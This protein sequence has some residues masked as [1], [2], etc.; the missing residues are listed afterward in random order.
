VNAC[1]DRKDGWI[2]PRSEQSVTESFNGSET[3]FSTVIIRFFRISL[4]LWLRIGF[5]LGFGLYGTILFKPGIPSALQCVDC[6]VSPVEKLLRRPGASSFGRSATIDDDLLV[7]R[8]LIHARVDLVNRDSHRS[9]YLLVA[10]LP[11]AFAS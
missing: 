3:C 6:F 5:R 1:S 11:R 10:T 7:L 9:L 4:E 8:L 2:Q